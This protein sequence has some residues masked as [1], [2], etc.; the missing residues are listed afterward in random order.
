MMNLL[1]LNLVAPK[2]TEE[3]MSLRGPF[4]GAASEPQSSL[5]KNK[6]MPRPG[7]LKTCQCQDQKSVPRHS[8]RIDPGIF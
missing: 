6:A 7:L 3:G 8:I 1:N 2:E 5:N 4:F